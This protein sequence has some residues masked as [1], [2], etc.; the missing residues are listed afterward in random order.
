MVA[1]T[2]SPEEKAEVWPLITSAFKGY[3]DYQK[4]TD[5]DIPV[6]ELVP[7]AG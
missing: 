7:A 4:K 2:L 1:R 6:V 3:A 5:R